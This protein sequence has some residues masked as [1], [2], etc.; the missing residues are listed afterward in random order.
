[1]KDSLKYFKFC[2]SINSGN[3]MVKNYINYLKEYE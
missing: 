3:E 2:E 1:F